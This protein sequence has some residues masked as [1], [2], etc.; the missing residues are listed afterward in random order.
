[1]LWQSLNQNFK[2]V[3]FGLPPPAFKILCNAL[4]GHRFVQT[5]KFCRTCVIPSA[6]KRCTKC[7]VMSD[8]FLNIIFILV[9]K[10]FLNLFPCAIQ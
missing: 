9:Y 6:K 10:Y 7:K 4:L 8:Y 2:T 3:E 5:S 1:M